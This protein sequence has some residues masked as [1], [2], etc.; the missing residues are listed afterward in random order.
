ME[1]R[2]LLQ[3]IGEPMSILGRDLGAVS[4]LKMFPFIGEKLQARSMLVLWKGCSAQS[5]LSGA[6]TNIGYDE[7]AER[8]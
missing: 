5:N 1:Q 8:R 7:F 2:I 3:V 6:R 4:S